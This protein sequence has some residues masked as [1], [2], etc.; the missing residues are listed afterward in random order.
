MLRVRLALAAGLG[1]TAAAVGAVLLWQAPVAVLGSNATRA[2]PYEQLGYTSGTTNACQTAERLPAHT[3]ALRLSLGAFTGS[4]VT[5]KVLSGTSVVT[6][7][8][9]GPGWDG[10]TVT[11]PL[12]ALAHTIYPARICFAIPVAGEQLTLF[13]SHVA[14]TAAARARDGE[15]SPGRI[16]IEYLG[17]GRSSWLSLVPSVARHIGLGRAWSGIW[18]AFL[19]PGLMLLALILASRL[20]V[21]ELDA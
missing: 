11:V 4:E 20:I 6:S 21:R 8:K 2:S 15:A 16:R 7:G 10:Q 3:V 1:I 9:R 5:V 17:K 14:G 12:R 18:V 19:I 13:G